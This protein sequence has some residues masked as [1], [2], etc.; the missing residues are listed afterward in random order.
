MTLSFTESDLKACAEAYDP[1]VFK[2]PLVVGHPKLAD[3]A[4]GWVA[5]LSYADG[6]L[7]AGP[8]QVDA[9]FAELVNDG[10]FPKVSASFYLPDSPNNPKPGVMYLKHVG[11]LGAAAP[12]IKGL[13]TVSFAAD[14]QGVVEFA[15]WDQMNIVGL[16]RGLREWIIGKFGTDEADKVLPGYQIESL[17]ISA[18][19]D[20]DDADDLNP[21]PSYSENDDMTPE[22]TAKMAAL[23][24]EN[25]ALKTSE[26]N[27]KTQVA[28]FAEQEQA[29]KVTVLHTANVSFAEGLIKEG[30][31]LP[32]TKDSAIALMDQLGA[33]ESAIEFGEGDAKVTE[34]PLE[35]YKKQLQAM[36]KQVEFGEAAGDGKTPADITL[37]PAGL[38]QKA[39][40]FAESEAS[41]G[42]TV[43][44]AQAVEHVKQT[45]GKTA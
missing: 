41:Q 14:E 10:K 6:L 21:L 8:D 34:T 17:Q 32:A 33:Q 22:Q 39:V 15:D 40:E 30:K 7:N 43:N 16:F 1:S 19:Q 44:S 18:V 28:S 38:A 27:L 4:Y 13:K 31:L 25:S 24:A 3:P 45:Y 5:S 36:P 9:N 12:A 29:R 26:A 35:T 37:D 2:A 11:F 20:N 42:R 23:E